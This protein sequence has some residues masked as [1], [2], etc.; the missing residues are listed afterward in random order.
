[1]RAALAYVVL[2]WSEPNR[3]LLAVLFCL[4]A[5]SMAVLDRLPLEGIVRSRWCEHFFVG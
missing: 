5:T 1:V 2:T 3:T 4:G